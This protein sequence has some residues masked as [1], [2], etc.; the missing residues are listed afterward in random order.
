MGRKIGMTKTAFLKKAKEIH[1]DNYDYSEVDIDATLEVPKH[2]PVKIRCKRH[3]YVFYETPPQHNL[4]RR[5]SYRKNASC[6]PICCHRGNDAIFLNGGYSAFLDKVE[7]LSQTMTRSQIAEKLNYRDQVPVKNPKTTSPSARTIYVTDPTLYQHI[8]KCEKNTGRKIKLKTHASAFN[9]LYKGKSGLIKTNW[10]LSFFENGIE[11]ERE[12]KGCH[13]ILPLDKFYKKSFASPYPRRECKKCWKINKIDAWHKNHPDYS[14][15]RRKKD[16]LYKL[17]CDLRSGVNR[18]LSQCKLRGTD[19]VK[20]DKTLNLLGAPSWQHVFDH[21]ESLFS[22]GMTWANH[23]RGDKKKEWHI[24]HIK[25]VD[26]F[27]KN[28]DFTLLE[29]QREC[30]NFLNLQPLWSTDNLKKSNRFLEGK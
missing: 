19:A 29:V 22:S 24:D 2:P 23:G 30:F 10:G 25:P 11:K 5:Y 21:I 4:Y 14:K 13:L 12:C 6:V 3:N 28:M 15:E 17:V 20:Q 27:I 7:G 8:T 18:A 16:P 26:Y 1:G 9:S